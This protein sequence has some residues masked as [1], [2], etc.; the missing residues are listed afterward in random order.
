M[1]LTFSWYHMG[2]KKIKSFKPQKNIPS[3]SFNGRANIDAMYDREWNLYSTKFLKENPTCLSCGN[4]SEVTDHLK[5]HKGD[6]KL[7]WKL[8][9]LIPLCSSCH[10]TITTLFDRFAVQKYNEKLKWIG[11]NRDL[12]QL[13]HI[14]VKVVPR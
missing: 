4:R 10:N 2:M 11:K 3:R 1:I 8:D 5:A 7:F 9:N 13:T 6:E 14:A 12:N